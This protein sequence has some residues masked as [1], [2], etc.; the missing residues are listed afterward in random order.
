MKFELD[1][2]KKESIAFH[3]LQFA[4]KAPTAAQINELD[5]QSATDSG[6]FLQDVLICLGKRMKSMD[7]VKVFGWQQHL[8]RVEVTAC[9]FLDACKL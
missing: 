2:S 8:Y 1:D 3:A 5:E 7:L 6:Q 4:K 9:V